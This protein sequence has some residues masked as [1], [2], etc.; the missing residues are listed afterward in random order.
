MFLPIPVFPV[1]RA[2]HES[3]LEDFYASLGSAYISQK[4]KTSFEVI[5]RSQQATSLTKQ[6]GER[7]R[8]RSPL[9]VSPSVTSRPLVSNAASILGDGQ[10]NLVEADDL[11]AVYSLGRTVRNQ[12]VTSCTKPAGMRKNNLYITGEFD[13]FD[14]GNAIGGLI[15]QRCQLEDAFFIGSLLEVCI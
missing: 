13:W 4:V 12:R 15:L 14:V 9:L 2:P 8:E 1:L 10:L 5:G 7:I 6:L 3:D 11:K